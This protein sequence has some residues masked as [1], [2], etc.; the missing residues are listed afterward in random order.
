MVLQ[1]II[2]AMRRSEG[3]SFVEL[4]FAGFMII[5]DGPRVLEYNV[6]FGNPETQTLLSIMGM[7]ADLADTMVAYTEGR[8]DDVQL[9][10]K[11]VFS[12]TVVAA[13]GGYTE[14]CQHDNTISI[15]QRYSLTETNHVFHAGAAL[16]DGSLKT[17]GGRKGTDDEPEPA[18]PNTHLCQATTPTCGE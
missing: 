7:E 18:H 17:I 15:D 4:Q 8:L 3:H 11:S 1:L 12:V 2:D 9:H 10:T 6:R 14:S 16:S 13:T 5:E